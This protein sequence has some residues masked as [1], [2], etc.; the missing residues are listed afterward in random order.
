MIQH[1]TQYWKQRESFLFSM[2]TKHC[3]SFSSCVSGLYVP[4]AAKTIVVGRI[5]RSSAP[6]TV[7]S[8]IRLT[9]LNTT[10]EGRFLTNSIL[11][12]TRSRRIARKRAQEKPP[13]TCKPTLALLVVKGVKFIT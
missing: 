6:G 7:R 9:L 5:A 10:P 12:L 13:P 3:L 8:T 1:T 2:F 11:S 4:P